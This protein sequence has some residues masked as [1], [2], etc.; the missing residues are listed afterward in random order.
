[1][2]HR[3]HR[4]IRAET[5]PVPV[6][7]VEEQSLAHTVVRRALEPHAVVHEAAER[8]RQSATGRIA[9]REMEE[10][11]RAARR[12]RTPAAFPGV[13]PDVM[14]V[15]AGGKEGRAGHLGREFEAQNV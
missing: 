11:R 12:R 6:R 8:L 15:A 5:C 13:E 4:W 1:P 9:D 7:G 2:W 3:G 14:V 10:A